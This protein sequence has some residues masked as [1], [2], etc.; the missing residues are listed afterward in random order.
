[1]YENLPVTGGFYGNCPAAIFALVDLLPFEMQEVRVRV[2]WLQ[3]SS[4]PVDV[5]VAD[6]SRHPVMRGAIHSGPET[7]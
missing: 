4:E 1:M 3:A 2:C 7:T 5:T 6:A